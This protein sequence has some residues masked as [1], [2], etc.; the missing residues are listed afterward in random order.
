M[1]ADAW[2]CISGRVSTRIQ[3]V[4]T[5]LPSLIAA[6]AD[7]MPLSFSTESR[8]AGLQHGDGNRCSGVVSFAECLV[9]RTILFCGVTVPRTPVDHGNDGPR[10]SAQAFP[11]HFRLAYVD[12]TPSIDH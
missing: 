7:P 6:Y 12:T 10:V 5:A 4:R 1:T 8:I 9:D 2:R 3:N 11:Q